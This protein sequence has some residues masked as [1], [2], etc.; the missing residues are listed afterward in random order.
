M[1]AALLGSPS[2]GRW[3]RL[4]AH[5]IAPVLLATSLG[6]GSE[7][8]QTMSSQLQVSATVLRRAH[9]N[10]VASPHEMQVSAQDVRRGYVEVPAGTVFTVRCNIPEG[11]LVQVWLDPGL[12]TGATVTGL[13]Y[14][15]ELQGS[16]GV[17]HLEGPHRQET[18]IAL[19]WVLQLAPGVQPGTYHWPVQ[20]QME[21]V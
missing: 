11:L 15:T 3:L 20:L 14:A 8:V 10:L 19:T 1:D 4:A 9:V 7:N 17:L 12:V 18:R 6:F 5:A 13:P 2:P 16:S 21:G